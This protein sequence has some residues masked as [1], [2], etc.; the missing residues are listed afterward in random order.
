MKPIRAGVPQGS[1]LSPQ[2]YPA[3]VN[4]IPR[5][6][7]G[8]QLVLFVDDTALYFRSNSIGNILPRLQR[9]T[10]ELTQWLRLLRIDVN[11]E[12]SASINFKYSPHKV[13]FLSSFNGLTPG[14]LSAYRCHSEVSIRVMTSRDFISRGD[15][16][17][18]PV[19]ESRTTACVCR[20]VAPDKLTTAFG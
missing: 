4:D 13:Q 2:L 11:P 9:A 20:S 1:T 8:V 7:T 17:G 19:G 3:Y 15:S 5:L 6:S 12:K 16:S 10:D 18:P 14:V